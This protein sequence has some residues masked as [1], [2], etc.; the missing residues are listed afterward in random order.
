MKTRDEREGDY[1]KVREE[2]K[3]AK[4]VLI[5]GAG[6]TGL[7]TAGYM[8]EKFPD[9]KIGIC[10]R[11]NTLLPYLDGVH[12]KIDL[13]LKSMGL[14]IHYGTPYVEGE[15]AAALGYD[16]A[17]D[18]RGYKFTAPAKFMTGGLSK[19]VDKKN[20]QIQVNYF[21]QVCEKYPLSIDRKTNNALD[22]F[23]NIFSVG[24]VC[25]T[26]L[27]ENKSIVAMM[28]YAPIVSHNIYQ[29]LCGAPHCSKQIPED[30]VV[31]QAIPL[32]TKSGIVCINNKVDIKGDVDAMKDDIEKK[33]LARLRGDPKSLQE[34]MKEGKDMGNFFGMLKSTCCCIMCCGCC[35]CH[36]AFKRGKDR[37]SV[38]KLKEEYEIK[39]P[40]G[41]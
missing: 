32:G 4:S 40:S 38:R 15:T 22:V 11:G 27:A 17:L 26:P 2:I 18:C 28:Q 21:G 39:F 5:V 13:H 24:D 3:A 8:K 20:G 9:H 7:E 6:A 34:G 30:I 35:G 14:E 12:A 16:Y 29:Q 37:A 10:L 25:L 41:N 19:C 23:K 36:Y 33:T 31:F 1:T